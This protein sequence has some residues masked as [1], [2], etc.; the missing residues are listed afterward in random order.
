MSILVILFVANN[1][2]FAIPIGIFVKSYSNI[3][4]LDIVVPN[5]V[6]LTIFWIWN[7]YTEQIEAHLAP[8]AVSHD[9]KAFCF[10]IVYDVFDTGH[11]VDMI[12]IDFFCLL[13]QSAH[14]N[15]N[16]V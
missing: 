12:Y 8:K 4:D 1:K 11:L 16:D 13:S 9:V 10:I 2:L 14:V 15:I 7:F 3:I 6:E 5:D